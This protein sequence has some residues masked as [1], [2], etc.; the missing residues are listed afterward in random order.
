MH[1]PACIRCCKT[2]GSS[3]ASN[4]SKP[5]WGQPGKD[6]KLGWILMRYTVLEG[7]A[8]S[9]IQ[10]LQLFLVITVSYK[11]QKWGLFSQLLQSNKQISREAEQK[12]PKKTTQDK[13][14]KTVSINKATVI[15]QGH[16][17]PSRKGWLEGDK[18]SERTN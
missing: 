18:G 7:Q 15:K 11:R 2:I 14:W 17:F 3:W 4:S 13:K 12:N 1:M 16:F 5:G 6:A 10:F 9:R 8:E